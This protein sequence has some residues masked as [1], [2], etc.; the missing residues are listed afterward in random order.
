MDWRW[1]DVLLACIRIRNFDYVGIQN[2]V[3][4]VQTGATVKARVPKTRVKPSDLRAQAEKLIADGMMPDLDTVLNA[5]EQVRT[6]YRARILEVRRAGE[7]PRGAEVKVV[8][9]AP[10]LPRSVRV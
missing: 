9:L 10:L 7:N 1:R 6:K 8:T 3:D 5:L 2:V 4:R